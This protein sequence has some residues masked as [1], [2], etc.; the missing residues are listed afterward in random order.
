LIRCTK[1]IGEAE[2]DPDHRVKVKSVDGSIVQTYGVIKVEVQEG[3]FRV[4]FPYHLVNKQ[5]DLVYDRILGMDFLQRTKANISYVSNRVTFEADGHKVMKEMFSTTGKHMEGHAKSMS[6]PKG[7]EITVELP[8]EKGEEGAKGIIDKLQTAEGIHVASSLTRIEGSKA[9]VSIL[10]TRNKEVVMDIPCVKWERYTPD[11]PD[12]EDRTSYV[13]AV[14]LV[15]T[16]FGQNR[17]KVLA[18]LRLDHLNSEERWA[19]EST[20]RNYQ[21]IFYIKGDH[22]SC[23]NAIKYN[24]SFIYGPY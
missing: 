13:G 7:S 1:L 22:F 10:N 6:L 23:T 19:I 9:I 4:R 5:V 12:G 20:C 15:E 14:A 17:E 3:N 24:R 21:D 2:F 18:N 16:K 11:S 8:A